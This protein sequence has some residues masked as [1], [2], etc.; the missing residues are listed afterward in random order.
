M[1]TCPAEVNYMH[2]IDHGRVHIEKTYKRPFKERFIRG[3]L[4]WALP[5][6]K[7]FKFILILVLLAKPFLFFFPKNLKE[8]I[9]FMPKKFPKNKLRNMEVYPAKNKKKP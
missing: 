6:P 1:T 5:N 8:M 4:S 9:N 7:N 3:F 2:L